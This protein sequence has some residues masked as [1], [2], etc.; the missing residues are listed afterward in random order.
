MNTATPLGTLGNFAA[1]KGLA[2]KINEMNTA[3]N[4]ASCSLVAVLIQK[5][6]ATR[7]QLAVFFAVFIFMIYKGLWSRLQ[8]SS[9]VLRELQP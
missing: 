1:L 7:L 2:F 5:K 8:D 6:A 4:T 3:K 9:S